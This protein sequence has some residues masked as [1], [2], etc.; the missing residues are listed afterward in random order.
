MQADVVFITI[1]PV[2]KYVYL[3][4]F[5]TLLAGFFYPLIRQLSFDGTVIAILTLFIGLA[6]G[7][8]LYKSSEVERY[9]EVFMA[10]GFALII[11][12]TYL[13]F[14]LSGRL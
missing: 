12:S 13:I 8:M 6:G 9:V 14:M 10:T 1:R 7:V 3:M 5:F 11:V 2:F 4:T